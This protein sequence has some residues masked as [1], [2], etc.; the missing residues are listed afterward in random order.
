MWNKIDK[1]TYMDRVQGLNVLE[2][3]TDPD[4]IFPTSYGQPHIVTVWGWSFPNVEDNVKVLKCEMKK[5][6]RHQQEWKTEYFEYQ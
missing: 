3:K 6:H 1:E 2:T 4:G 5:Q